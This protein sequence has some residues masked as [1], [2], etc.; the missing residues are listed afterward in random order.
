[1]SNRYKDETIQVAA[2]AAA[3]IEDISF[4]EANFEK[5]LPSSP[6]KQG[7]PVLAAIA[8]ERQKQDR[9]WGPQHHDPF[10]WLM[11]LMEEVGEVAEEVEK[12][13]GLDNTEDYLVWA[14]GRMGRAAKRWLEKRNLD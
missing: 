2:V 4:G 1:M 12:D 5:E 10:T 13:A 14:V 8:F 11:I 9:K 3:M 7:K 6:Q